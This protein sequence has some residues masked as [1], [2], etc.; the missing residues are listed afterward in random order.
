MKIK[1]E[2]RTSRTARTVVLAGLALS[3]VP[4]ASAQQLPRVIAP[5]PGAVL[6]NIQETEQ[7]EQ[8]EQQRE[9][10]KAPP[11]VTTQPPPDKL[12]PE[13]LEASILVQGF[14]L[15]GV[16][17]LP[18]EELQE[19]LRP[20]I[21]RSLTLPELI[22]Q[23]QV[24]T[25]S[26]ARQGYVAR[27]LIPEQD[28]TDG[29]VRLVVLE[30]RLGVINIQLGDDVRFPPERVRNTLLARQQEGEPIRIPELERSM[31]LL[32]DFGG[33]D[34]RSALQPGADPGLTDENIYV[35][36][37]PFVAGSINADNFGTRSV[38]QNQLSALIRLNN[39]DGR[40]G[41]ATL[42]AM[43]MFVDSR[44]NTYG[45]LIYAT[46]IGYDG[47]SLQ[48]GASELDY[49]LGEQFASLNV[50][51]TSTTYFAGLSY[52]IVRSGNQNLYASARYEHLKLKATATSDCVPLTDKDV[53]LM[54]IGLA[55]DRLDGVSDSFL[56]GSGQLT[57][58]SVRFGPGQTFSF[59]GCGNSVGFVQVDPSGVEGNFTKI[60]AAASYQRRLTE[61]LT[62]S[63]SGS[64]QYA[65]TNLDTSQQMT[66]GGPFGVRAYP[67][68]EAAG[69]QGILA[70]IELRYRMF[71]GVVG[72][73]FV[74]GGHIHRL[75]EVPSG[76]PST[77]NDV[78]LYGA[79]FGLYYTQPGRFNLAAAVAWRIGENPLRNV[80]GTDSD[81]L[82][83]DP[84]FWANLSYF[85]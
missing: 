43:G 6:R 68:S 83:R 67:V 51:G 40:G 60:S 26:Y 13:H 21:G 62:W 79:G 77:H 10:T 54:Q 39:V 48:L 29:V 61:N 22:R 56:T 36:P 73:A 49:R 50:K 33:I 4:P 41:S 53:D 11:P 65:F 7:R 23:V 42:N 64:G 85:F 3:V 78:S 63:L 19:L 18:Q 46:P 31:L 45:S 84:R 72:S 32:N 27:T 25:A 66:L 59:P 71:G 37:L 30:G 69:D 81:G 20:M 44:V 82:K 70:N 8:R 58:G 12:G 15:D 5:D 1:K 16:T 17:L 35:R 24:V 57:S 9:S 2:I 14:R 34:V 80:T 38:G 75:H 76:V 74:D 28:I 55:F 52:P 47:L